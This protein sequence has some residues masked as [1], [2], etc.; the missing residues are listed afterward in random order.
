MQSITSTKDLKEVIHQVEILQNSQRELLKEQ[1]ELTRES[2][3]PVSLFRN[4]LGDAFKSPKIML[5]IFLAAAGLT[6]TFFKRKNQ[7]VSNPSLFKKLL[8]TFLQYR[9]KTFLSELF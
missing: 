5:P 6:V 2:L 1:L 9:I 8:G 7:S 3:K 4:M